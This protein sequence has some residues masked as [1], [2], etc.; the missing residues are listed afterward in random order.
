MHCRQLFASN[1]KPMCMGNQVSGRRKPW[2]LMLRAEHFAERCGRGKRSWRC[3]PSNPCNGHQRGPVCRYHA[4]A[5]FT[6]RMLSIQTFLW[7]LAA[8][9]SSTSRT[10]AKPR[11]LHH[12]RLLYIAF[13]ESKAISGLTFSW[14]RRPLRILQ[15]SSGSLRA[16]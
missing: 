14:V 6:G 9:L 10:F 11:A 3:I 4:I 1:K 13:D 7:T 12:P 15:L 16:N 8:L 2:L 5:T